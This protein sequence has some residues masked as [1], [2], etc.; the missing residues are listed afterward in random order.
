L[1]KLDLILKYKYI[2]ELDPSSDQNLIKSII[3]NDH[4]LSQDSPSH[5][6][7]F[8]YHTNSQPS[9]HIGNNNSQN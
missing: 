6:L 4:P 1:D 8:S 3:N 7:N 5:L 2:N 9:L